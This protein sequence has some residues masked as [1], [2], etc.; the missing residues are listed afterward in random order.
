MKNFG[1]YFDTSLLRNFRM[2]MYYIY[3]A[4][5]KLLASR[6]K[7]KVSFFS[8]SMIIKIKSVLTEMTCS[9]FSADARMF[10]PRLKAKVLFFSC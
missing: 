6:L 7:A 9:N 8:S 4:L 3:T 5:L 2:L 10:A 1:F